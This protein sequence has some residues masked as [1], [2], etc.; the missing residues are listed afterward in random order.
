MALFK[1]WLASHYPLK[2]ER[3]M[4]RV[5]DLRG[6]RESD[7]R[8]GQR[9]KGQGVFADL[10]AQRFRRACGTLGLNKSRHDLATDRFRPPPANPAQMDMF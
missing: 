4:G 1:D 6:G 2:Y 5:R 3:V 8:F 9:M 10:L 7:A